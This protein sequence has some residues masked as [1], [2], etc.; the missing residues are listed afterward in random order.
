MATRPGLWHHPDFLLFWL[1]QSLSLVG[2]QFGALA[3][4][5]VAIATL[6]AGAGQIGI[7]A[8]LSTLPWLLFGPLVGVGLDRTRRKPVLVAAHLFRAA[9]LLTIPLAA[10]L[11]RLTLGHLYVATFLVGTLAVGFETARHAYLPSLVALDDLAEANSKTAITDGATRVAGP[12]GAGRATQWLGPPVAIAAQAVLLAVAGLCTWRIRRPESAPAPTPD[13]DVLVALR[14]GMAYLWGARRIRALILSDTTFLFFFAAMQAVLVVFLTRRLGLAPGAIG[15]LFAVG[16]VGGVLGALVAHRAARR[17]PEERLIL[18]GSLLRCGGLALI[19]L[20]LLA[21]PLAVAVIGA[22]RVI[23]AFG[24]TLWQVYQETALQRDLPAHLR[25][26]VS[27]G[28]LFLMRAGETFGGFAGAGL[29]ATLGVT[30]TLVIAA[31]GTALGTTW[32]LP[33]ARRRRG[34]ATDVRLDTATGRDT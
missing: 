31:L 15:A 27:G 6:G 30:P 32:L 4:P 13:R 7:L 10:A 16:G 14:E 21:G 3:L 18:I 23:H 5:L 29:A 22:A 34:A 8:G 2:L 20:C 11:G 19:P 25:G 17:L 26:R 1:G 9:L 12:G 28:A 24:W 33:A